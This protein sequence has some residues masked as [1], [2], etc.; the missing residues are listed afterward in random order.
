MVATLEYKRTEPI[1]AEAYASP[2]ICTYSD[3]LV[4]VE[5]HTPDPGEAHK[6]Q[7]VALANNPVN[8]VDPDG[9]HGNPISGGG[10]SIYSPVG[11]W[12]SGAS[13]FRQLNACGFGNVDRMTKPA[14]V[15]FAAAGAVVGVGVAGYYAWPYMAAAGPAIATKAGA[16]RDAFYQWM[17]SSPGTIILEYPQRAA[18]T[19]GDWITH[20]MPIGQRLAEDLTPLAPSFS[21]L[22][23]EEI[24]MGFPHA[25]WNSGNRD[26]PYKGP[27][28]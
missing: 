13:E 2:L 20:T 19:R 5:V 24:P 15:S 6:N 9:L 23:L 18:M 25:I 17:A 12:N 3:T 10:D 8:F 26:D 1:E 28:D 11:G 27:C 4:T 22:F 7:Y 16:I 21:Q 14:Q